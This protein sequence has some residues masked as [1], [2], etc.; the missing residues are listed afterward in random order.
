MFAVDR[1]FVG[2]VHILTTSQIKRFWKSI[3]ITIMILGG[4]RLLVLFLLK[5]FYTPKEITDYLKS[6]NENRDEKYTVYDLKGLLF[7]N[8]FHQYGIT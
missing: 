2:F 1:L 3:A 7:N 6:I 5:K 4:R 8:P